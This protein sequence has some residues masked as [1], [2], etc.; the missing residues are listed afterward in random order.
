MATGDKT[1]IRL[2]NGQVMIHMSVRKD[3][4]KPKLPIPCGQFAALVEEDGETEEE[5]EHPGDPCKTCG[6]KVGEECVTDCWSVRS[7]F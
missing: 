5:E 6:A 1:P 4:R 7:G 2:E 3:G